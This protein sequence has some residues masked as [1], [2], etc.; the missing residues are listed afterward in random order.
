MDQNIPSVPQQDVLAKSYMR[1]VGVEHDGKRVGGFY[2]GAQ[3]TGSYVQ[4]PATR[5][6]GESKTGYDPRYRPWYATIASGPKDVVI[7]A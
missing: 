5:T 3:A 4:W 2:A 1:V 7:G 6:C